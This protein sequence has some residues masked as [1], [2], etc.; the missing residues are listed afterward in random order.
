M[1]DTLNKLYKTIE[2]RK[3]ASVDKSYVASLLQGGTE[4]IGRKVAEEATEVLIASLVESKE[5]LISESADLVFHLLVLL[6]I[7]DI[8]PNEVLKVLEE[9][10]GI[11][12]LDEKAARD[13]KKKG[14]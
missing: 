7:R 12:G 6:S 1:S 11:S 5:E 10:M 4:K 3:T 8:H 13:A 2:E 14:K 9:R